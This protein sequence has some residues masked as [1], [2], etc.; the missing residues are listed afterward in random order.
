MTKKRTLLIAPCAVLGIMLAVYAACGLFPFG[1]GTVSWCDM[2][3]QVIPLL[4]DFRDILTG[5]ADLF[6]NL[7]NAGGMSFWGVFL[8][9]LSSPF[10]FL[11]LLV[12]KA[13]IYLLV[14]VLL[15]LKMMTCSVTACLFFRRCFPGLDTLQT[16]ALSVMYAFCGYTMFYYQNLVWLDVMYLF[17]VLLIGLDLLAREGRPAAYVIA[18]SA[19]LTVN[20]YLSYMVSVFLV[21][22]S[23]AYLLLCVP[24][25]E[26]GGR[27]AL[28]GVSTALSALVTAVVWL[29]SLRQYLSSGRTGDLISSLRAGSFFTRFD[30][31]VPVVVSTGGAAAALVMTL[32]LMKKKSGR[33]RWALAVLF[34]TLVPVLIEPINKMWQTGSYQSFPV[35]YGYIPVFFGLIL[36]AAVI[37]RAN[38]G[39][40]HASGGTLPFF[41]GLVALG[42]VLLSAGMLL[43]QDYPEITVYTRTLWGDGASFR[44]LL[45]FALT[46]ALAYLILLLLYRYERLGRTV[47][48]VF[49]CVLAAAEGA[50]Y[51]NVYIGSAANDAGYYAGIL[52]LEGRIPDGGLYRVKTEQKYFDVNLIGGLGYR[53]LSHYTSLTSKDY[54]F[55]MKKLGYSSY[56]MEVNSNGGTELSDALLGNEYVITG[57]GSTESGEDTVYSNGEYALKKNGISLPVGLV[58]Q[59]DD[60]ASL[61][62]LPDTTRFG[63]QQSLF[64]SV[65]HTD[66]SLMTEYGPSSFD[67]VSLQQAGGKNY[68]LLQDRT[69]EGSVTY[70]IPVEGTQ[71]LYFDC[72]DQLTNNLYEHIDS[73]FSVEVNGVTLETAYPTQPDN[74]LVNLGT[75]S[76][77]TVKVRVGVL[78]DVDAKSFGVAGLDVGALRAAAQNVGKAQLR[79]E[80][81]RIVGTAS[82]ADGGSYLFLPLNCDGGYSATVNGKRAEIFRVFDSFM[83]VKLEKGAN[84]VSV[85]YVPGGFAA[86]AVLSALGVLLFL[87]FLFALHK[88]RRGW[89]RR[90]ETPAGAA[91][92]LL[93]AA[94]FFL[95]YLFPVAVYL[96]R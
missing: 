75:F 50:F 49:L 45:L 96:S 52:D 51:A 46:A 72:F 86:G 24:R 36:L 65:F 89:L 8:F 25:K 2:N 87:L 29:P 95:V 23:G 40:D 10:S 66:R 12:G 79:Q 77:E 60:I 11:V 31:T 62:A 71:T 70:E 16:C 6:L 83:A 61:K 43:R 91:F 33:L 58:M 80:G 22:A 34:L 19:V 1:S 42:A 18:L 54:M 38:A 88:G 3:Q 56:W 7:Q 94:V 5:K 4:M 15:I 14:N 90:L 63:I 37:S 76:D 44:F 13:Q 27:A 81:N 93:C 35:R 74:G 28:L 47:F 78:R 68:L 26:R 17:P 32:F 9:F 85:S 73:S 41:I 30:T 82:A 59:S 84:E 20:F 69:S 53:S 92:A 67:N 64:Q 57:A 48:S 39:A 21:L 55:A